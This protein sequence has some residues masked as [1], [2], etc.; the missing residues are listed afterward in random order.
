[1]CAEG[2]GPREGMASP[3]APL[4][5]LRGGT[6]RERRAS[7]GREARGWGV[8]EW[9]EGGSERGREGGMEGVEEGGRGIL[10]GEN[11]GGGGFHGRRLVF[12]STTGGLIFR[13]HKFNLF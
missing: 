6:D 2:W 5:L 11:I 12:F 10:D 13:N 8:G 7:E 1:M 9:R 3:P 4:P